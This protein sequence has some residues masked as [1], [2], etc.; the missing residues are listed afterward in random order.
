MTFWQTAT[1]EQKLAQIDGG[2][3]CGM[4]SVQI[5]MNCGTYCEA[6]ITLGAY[7][8]RKIPRNYG[9]KSKRRKSERT[10]CENMKRN[11]VKLGMPSEKAFS[12]FDHQ[13]E[14]FELEWP[15]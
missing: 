5:A 6:V 14:P 3:E 12:I 15:A 13:P 11:S 4:N 2:I 1:T 7:H 8:G 9:E 10:R